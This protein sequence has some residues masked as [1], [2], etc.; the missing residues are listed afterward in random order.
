MGAN[1]QRQ[2]GAAAATQRAAGREPHGS[3]WLPRTPARGGGQ[4]RR[5]V[6]AVSA[7]RIIVCADPKEPRSDGQGNGSGVDIYTL[8]KFR[9][10][11]AEHLHQPEAHRGQGRQGRA[12]PGDRRTGRPRSRAS[13]RWARTSWWLSCP[14]AATTSRTSIL[15]S[16]RLVKDDRYT[17]IHIEEFEIEARDTSAARK[18]SPETSQRG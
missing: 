4:A 11:N 12:G 14:G 18:R 8:M 5:V 1:M 17:S 2:A 15:I 3:S 7:A 10:S 13:W 9:R 16:E 6:E